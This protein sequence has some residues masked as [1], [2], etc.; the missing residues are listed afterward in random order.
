MAEPLLRVEE[1]RTC[2]DTD[3]G[4]ITAVDGVSFELDAG[5]TLAVVGESG[6]GKSVTAL[7]ILRLMATPPG[8]SPAGE[9]LLRASDLLRAPKSRDA[10]DPRQRD[11]DDLPGAD[12][13]R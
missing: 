12:D 1:L 3:A 4:V 11:R 13:E 6:C 9:I 5:E 7:S 8:A 2:F 10:A